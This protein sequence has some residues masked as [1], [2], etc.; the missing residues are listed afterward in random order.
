M[1][2]YIGWAL[3]A[4]FGASGAYAAT[5][6]APNSVSCVYDVMPPEDRENA[7]TLMLMD[8][9]SKAKAEKQGVSPA[10][11]D[12][13]ADEINKMV[14]EAYGKCLDAHPWSNARA[15]LAVL[16][17]HVHL[18]HDMS[19]RMVNIVGL[20]TADIDN[21]YTANRP[22]LLRLSK[23]DDALTPEYRQAMLDRGW[24]QDS[25]APLYIGAL[26]LYTLSGMDQLK[27]S[28]AQ[29]SFGRNPPPIIRDFIGK[30]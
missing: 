11:P 13:G 28:S 29:N 8:F 17:A 16:Y 19:A 23:P 5:P 12:A 27:A 24:P 10:K 9:D 22:R 4:G 14:D 3:A 15:G 26:Y 7:I 30:K 18:M 25:D 20:S 21:Y 2:K 1:L 6:A